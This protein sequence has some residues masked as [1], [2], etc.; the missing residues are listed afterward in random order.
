MITPLVFQY[1]AETA[2]TVALPVWLVAG[3]GAPVVPRVR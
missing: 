2:F 1:D 3:R